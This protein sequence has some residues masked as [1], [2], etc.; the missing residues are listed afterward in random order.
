MSTQVYTF[1]TN[2]KLT[3]LSKE[4]FHTLYGYAAAPVAG[5]ENVG[6]WK[7]TEILTAGDNKANRGAKFELTT[8]PLE[9]K[10]YVAYAVYEKTTDADVIVSIANGG[11]Y[12]KY[13]A[14]KHVVKVDPINFTATA[15]EKAPNA[16]NGNTA[17]IYCQTPGATNTTQ[18][19]G[20]LNELFVG[21]KVQFDYSK[22]HLMLRSS[23]SSS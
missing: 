7:V 13:V 20:D 1:S 17:S 18:I 11:M 14:I 6:T 21:G 15:K 19:I 4:Q 9:A 3:A 8:A 5:F 23:S 22:S 12:P 16:W 2:E 10:T